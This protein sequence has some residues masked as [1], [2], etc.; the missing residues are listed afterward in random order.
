M[1]IGA[2][3]LAVAACTQQQQATPPP[4]PHY[5]LTGE[6]R[7]S[8]YYLPGD[9]STSCTLHAQIQND[10]GPGHGGVAELILNFRPNTSGG[11]AAATC[12]APFPPME[13]KDI[14]EIDC[15]IQTDAPFRSSD[16]VGTDIRILSL[17][18]PASATRTYLPSP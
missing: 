4:P 6:V 17:V 18:G 1:A 3:G 2:C 5:R 13:S 16:I 7:A 10:G 9:W 12:E 14:A 8:C 15:K 11:P